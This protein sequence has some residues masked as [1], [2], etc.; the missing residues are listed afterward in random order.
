MAFLLQN[1]FCT[2]AKSWVI[3]VYNSTLR[4][5]KLQKSGVYTHP[6][7]W[8]LAINSP[9]FQPCESVIMHVIV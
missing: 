1:N 5:F 9:I 3:I 2:V 6:P 8:K 7:P 4:Q